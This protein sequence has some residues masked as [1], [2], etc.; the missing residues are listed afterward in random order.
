VDGGLELLDEA[1]CRELL[2]HGVVGR[3]GLTRKALP[4]ILPVNYAMI[5]E[6]V[7]FWSAPGMKLDAAHAQTVVA[8]EVD[9]FDEIQRCGWSVLVVGVAREVQDPDIIE[10]A[11]HIGLQPW[12]DGDRGHLVQIGVEFISGR[13]ITHSSGPA[14]SGG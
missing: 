4:V 7:T 11:R 12:V 6:Q 3:V 2:H 9:R 1:Q 5:D 10:A 14:M 13:R 8:F